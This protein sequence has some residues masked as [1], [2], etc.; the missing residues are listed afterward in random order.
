M[1][2]QSEIRNSNSEIQ[3]GDLIQY[4]YR[5]R[6]FGVPDHALSTQVVTEVIDGGAA[7]I[8]EGGFRIEK[9]QILTH[10]PMHVEETKSE[11]R[12]VATGQGVAD[13]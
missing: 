6:S 8:V 7:F 4:R 11:P 2:D 13:E 12:A 9:S 10:I 5:W 1:Q 3:V